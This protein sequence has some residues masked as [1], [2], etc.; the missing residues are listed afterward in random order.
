VD[1]VQLDR[2]MG[3]WYEVARCPN[4]FQSSCAGGST[5]YYSLRDDGKVNV[6]NSCRRGSMDG[7]IYQVEG[8]ARVVDEQTNAKLKVRFGLFSG[9][10]WII[11]LDEGYQWAVVGEPT[12]SYLW[13]LSRTPQMSAETYE[14]ILLLVEQKGY[15]PERLTKTP[16][17]GD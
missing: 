14:N 8:V 11:G 7:E 15:N 12:R 9:N 1:Q 13:I 5:A 6:T 17:P 10:Y 2:Y 4:F 16:Q 3:L